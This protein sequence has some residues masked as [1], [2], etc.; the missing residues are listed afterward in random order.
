MD[1]LEVRE[2]VMRW[3]GKYKF[4]LL[5]LL[6]GIVLMLIPQKQDKRE[7]PAVHTEEQTLLSEEL[8]AILANIKGAGKVQVLLSL[9]AGEEILYQTDGDSEKQNT[10]IITGSDRI[11]SGLVQ[12]I[13]PPKYQGAIILCQGADKPA[14]C[15]AITDAVSKVTGLDSSKISVLKMK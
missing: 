14:V 2:K 10:V 6:L 4:V 8:E 11:E 13:L 1:K 5:I 3:L 7:T 12:Q 9:K 15:L